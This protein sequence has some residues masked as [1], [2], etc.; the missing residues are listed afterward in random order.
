[1]D[2]KRLGATPPTPLSAVGRSPTSGE[3]KAVPLRPGSYLNIMAVD[4]T[5]TMEHD[6]SVLGAVGNTFLDP[7]AI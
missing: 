3:P 7:Y 6:E 5:K 4:D 2:A 1:M